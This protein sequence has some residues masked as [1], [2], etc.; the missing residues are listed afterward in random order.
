MSAAPIKRK[1]MK[2]TLYT[3]EAKDIPIMF[4]L[5]NMPSEEEIKMSNY[6]DGYK[7]LLL[8]RRNKIAK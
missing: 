5:D 4:S 7:Q 6:S 1:D 3:Y 8:N 2:K